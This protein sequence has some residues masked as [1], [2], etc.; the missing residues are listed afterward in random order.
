MLVLATLGIIGSILSVRRL[1]QYDSET[2]SL[3]YL[4]LWLSL[5]FINVGYTIYWFDH[6][7]IIQ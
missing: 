2:D 7:K 4:I 5:T 6:L 1:L 3:E